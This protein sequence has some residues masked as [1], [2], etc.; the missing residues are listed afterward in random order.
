M[1]MRRG[2]VGFATD[3]WSSAQDHTAILRPRPRRGL[4]GLTAADVCVSLHAA[5]LDKY[6]AG[7][8]R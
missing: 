4:L 8:L 6:S 1:D 7:R 5:A 3:A 2:Q